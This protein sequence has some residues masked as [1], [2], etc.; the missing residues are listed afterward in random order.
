MSMYKIDSKND[1]KIV[2]AEW[3]LGYISFRFLNDNKKAINHFKKAYENSTN[4]I[5]ISKNAFW[6]A[7]VYSKEKDV[8]FA[9][10]WYKKS[11]KY[12]STFYGYISEEK[13]KYLSKKNFSILA[14]KSFENERV[15]DSRGAAFAFYNR[16]LV[17]ILLTVKDKSMRKYF[18]Q[19]L[20]Y[21]IEDPN[22]EILLMDIA[23]AND[24]I[25]ILISENS[26][27]QHYFPNEKAYKVLES[28]DM[29]HVSKIN[30]D[31]CLMSLVH[32][33]IQRESNFNEDAKS[34][35]GAIG[36]MQVM[37]STA[38][39]EAKRLKFHI[40]NVSLFDK[41]KNITI[42]ASIL[43]R[44]LKKYK[45]N[46]IYTAAAY[47]C[48]EGGVLKYTKS[49]SNLKNLTPLDIIELIPIKETR[50]YVK[51]VVRAMFTYQKKFFANTCYNCNEIINIQQNR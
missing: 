38:Q 44:L 31:P 24:E 46:V 45:G 33:I 20:I 16:E 26:K 21:E 17:Q 27:R 30:T 22:E 36:M 18:Y 28:S 32:S 47:N 2:K 48:G 34:Y 1:E 39:Y 11:S 14:D 15:L 29:K 5:H 10:D 40:G 49:I 37:P 3:L 9:I 6:L 25:D 13:L 23:L 4:A 19:Q 43:N 50:I 51:H 42:G 12:F 8:V 41:Q 35:V 7:E